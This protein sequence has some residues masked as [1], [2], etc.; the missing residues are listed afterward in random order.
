[1]AFGDTAPRKRAG[2]W[3][4][5]VAKERQMSLIKCEECGH[6]VSSKAVSCPK[7]GARVGMMKS[8]W[9][10]EL[11]GQVSWKRIGRFFA[12]I[13]GILAVMYVFGQIVANRELTAE[14]DSS[15][16]SSTSSSSDYG[17]PEPAAEAAAPAPEFAKMEMTA[18]RGEWVGDF[19]GAMADPTESM[20]QHHRIL[21][22]R[23]KVKNTSNDTLSK[24]SCPARLTVEFE[25][26]RSVEVGAEDVCGDKALIGAGAAMGMGDMRSIANLTLGAGVESEFGFDKEV[27]TIIAKAGNW[28]AVDGKY[29][30]YPVKSTVL[31]IDYTGETAFGDPVQGS[32]VRL[33]IPAP[34][35]TAPFGIIG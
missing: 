20:A 10:A 21:V 9:N 29:H 7:C 35:E 4:F 25:N 18:L 5:G 31:T 6:E 27:T 28:L 1:V 24:L 3:G 16:Q 8:A 14:Y 13:F 23:G 17:E 34:S 22:L 32:L 19:I 12:V 15:E 33:E 26:G 30:S 2:H 11:T